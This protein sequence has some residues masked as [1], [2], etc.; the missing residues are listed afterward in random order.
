M[1]ASDR[2]A[3]PTSFRLAGELAVDV[4]VPMGSGD[5]LVLPGQVV[6][7]SGAAV[8]VT[9]ADGAAALTVAATPRC[10]L[11]WGDDGDE[12][13]AMVRS[14]RRVDDVRSPTTIEVVLEEVRPMPDRV[15]S[16]RG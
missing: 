3:A 16:R 14:G 2:R 15:P 1:A 9:M 10:V 6:Q 4:L 7:V 12:T 5:H 11:V 13:F 8:T